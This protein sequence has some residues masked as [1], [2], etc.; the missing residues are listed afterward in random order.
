MRVI[1]PLVAVLIVAAFAWFVWAHPLLFATFVA[2]AVF[3]I[4]IAAYLTEVS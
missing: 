4:R 1:V 2:L 3:L